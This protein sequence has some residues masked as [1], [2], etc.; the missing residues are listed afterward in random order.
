[1]TIFT[2]IIEIIDV[3]VTYTLTK[4]GDVPKEIRDLRQIKEEQKL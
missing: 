2:K 4:T 3:E 1:M